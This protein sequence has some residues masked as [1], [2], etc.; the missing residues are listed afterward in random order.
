MPSFDKPDALR[1]DPFGKNEYLRSTKG[2]LFTSA[3]VH[4]DSIT[5]E[6]WKDGQN[7]QNTQTFKLLQT[8]EVICKITSG[9]MQGYF[10]P[11]QEGA[12]DGR[13][14]VANIAGLND[15]YSPDKFNRRNNEVA[16]CYKGTALRQRVFIRDSTGKRKVATDAVINAMRGTVGL[17]LLFKS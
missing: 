14:D 5:A 6:Q 3:T 1:S 9:P 17:D 4:K 16:V 12:T 15:T 13:A 2:N 8:G 10:G 7:P 11:Y